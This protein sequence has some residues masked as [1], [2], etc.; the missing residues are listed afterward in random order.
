MVRSITGAFLTPGTL[1]KRGAGSLRAISQ[2]RGLGLSNFF[3]LH[4]TLNPQN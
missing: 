1:S 4:L 3:A 2:D